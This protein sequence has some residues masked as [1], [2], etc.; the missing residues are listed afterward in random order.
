MKTI[1]KII[2][3]FIAF[4]LVLA[5]FSLISW[6]IF[7]LSAVALWYYTKKELNPKFQKIAAVALVFS[8]FGIALGF[9]DGSVENETEEPKTEEVESKEEKKTETKEEKKVAEAESSSEEPEPVVEEEPAAAP[10][11]A[12]VV[13]TP[14]P[15]VEQ[16]SSVTITPDM[17]LPV[18][19]DSF[20]GTSV[21]TYD[22]SM[23]AFV[24]DVYEPGMVQGVTAMVQGYVGR[25]ESGWD[26]LV[27]QF[28]GLS[29]STTDSLGTGYSIMVKSPFSENYILWV[30]DSV[31]IYNFAD[32]L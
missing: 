10:A 8:F 17:I 16:P 28:V 21:V 4:A 2:G 19:Q 27:Q 9:T 23:K 14:A 26:N 15:V 20:A 25:E 13:Q 24:L 6:P 30:T 22:A 31:V 7:I 11:P 18:M 5:I 1:G 32:D 29:G 3:V 12:P